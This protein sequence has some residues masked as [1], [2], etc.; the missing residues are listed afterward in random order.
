MSA[1]Y[2]VVNAIQF[3]ATLS[4][5]GVCSR[6]PHPRRFFLFL[7]HSAFAYYTIFDATADARSYTFLLRHVQLSIKPLHHTYDEK[8]SLSCTSIFPIPALHYR[9]ALYVSQNHPRE[10]T[11]TSCSTILR[12]K[13]FV[14]MF[15]LDGIQFLSSK[16]HNTISIHHE[17]VSHRDSHK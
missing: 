17:L 1:L 6:I 15:L 3:I 11:N 5:H 14:S 7:S 13:I 10:S 12:P 4:P 16:K 2:D 9:S 8:I